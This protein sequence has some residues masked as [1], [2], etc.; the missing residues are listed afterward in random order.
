M[1]EEGTDHD[2]VFT[3]AVFVGD[4]EVARGE[5]RAKQEAEQAAAQAAIDSG[6]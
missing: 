1:A 2:K 4:R 5:G 3:V 6:Y